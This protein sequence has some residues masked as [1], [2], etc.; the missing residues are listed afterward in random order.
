MGGPDTRKSVWV[1]KGVMVKKATDSPPYFAMG[2]KSKSRKTGRDM[3]VWLLKGRAK[4]ISQTFK[5]QEGKTITRQ[6]DKVEITFIKRTKDG[7]Y[8]YVVNSDDTLFATVAATFFDAP[9]APTYA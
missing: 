1:P 2:F 8:Q 3:Y 4:P 9:Y 7:E 5:T 6:T